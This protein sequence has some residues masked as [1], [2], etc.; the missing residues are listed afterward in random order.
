MTQRLEAADHHA[1]LFAGVHV[2]GRDGDRF[3]HRTHGFGAGRGDADVYAMLKRRQT[4]QSNQLR[5]AVGQ[6]QLSGTA[7]VLGAVTGGHHTG[8]T[9]FDQK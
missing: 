8:S 4:I 6:S 9:A 1:K 5:R 3:V 7:T 2:F